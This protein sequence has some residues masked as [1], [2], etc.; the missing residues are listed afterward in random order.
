MNK[1]F[2]QFADKFLKLIEELKGTKIAVLGHLRPDGDCIGSQVALCRCLNEL[3][4]DTLAINPDPVPRTLQPFV[5]DTPFCKITDLQKGDRIAINVDCAAPDRTG[6]VLQAR[7]PAIFAN[8]DHHISN[9]A[10][11]RYNFVCAEASAT[12]EMLAGLFLDHRLPLDSVTAQALYVGIA[13]DTGQFRYPST[14]PQVF[15]ICGDLFAYG[16]D[17]AAAARQLYERESRAKMH[18]LQRFLASFRFMC[19]DHACVGVLHDGI[20]HETGAA[21]EDSEGLVEYTRSIDG[22]EIGVLLEEHQGKIKGSFRSKDPVHRVDLL[23]RQFNGGGHACA[24]GFNCPGDLASTFARLQSV[25][26]EHFATLA[27][28]SRN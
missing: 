28:P 18:L 27:A 23:A 19:S 20:Y 2:P 9:R 1:Y 24:A 3:G 11:A 12:A 7:F 13:T 25:L 21:R 16:A 22:V 6:Q 14:T 15:Q 17:P 4:V 26:E 5:A 8:I 10:Y